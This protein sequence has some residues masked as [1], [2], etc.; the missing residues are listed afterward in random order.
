MRWVLSFCLIVAWCCGVSAQQLSGE[1]DT[2]EP[3]PPVASTDTASA[4]GRGPTDVTQELLQDELARTVGAPAAEPGLLEHWYAFKDR[5]KKN[6]NFEFGL[7]YTATYQRASEDIVGGSRGV[8]L[9]LRLYDYLDLSPPGETP[10]K[11][12]AG[13]IFEFQGKWT[14]IRPNTPNRGFIGFSVESR[15][16]LGTEIPP[17]NLFLDATAIPACP[18]PLG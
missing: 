1:P 13:G 11:E 15:H 12:A 7:A 4:I 2:V 6:H 16:K 5:L 3:L 17:Q 8:A 9:L 14:L 10:T 18:T